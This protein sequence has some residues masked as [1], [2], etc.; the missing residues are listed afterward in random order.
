MKK[1]L[2]FIFVCIPMLVQAYDAEIDGIYYNFIDDEAE[3]TYVRQY[4][5]DYSGSITIPASVTFNGK[6]YPVTSIGDFAFHECDNLTSIVIPESVTNIGNAAFEG[7]RYLTNIN[8]PD[9]VITIG[10]QAFES[11]Y[12]LTS[13]VIPNGVTKIEDYTFKFCESMTSI[14]IPNSVTSIGDEAFSTCEFTNITI[15]N[16]VTSIGRAA[17]SHCRLLKTIT[18]PEGVTS[19]ES[20]TFSDCLALTDINI[21]ESVTSIGNIAFRLCSSL[22]K[23]TIPK[24][25]TKLGS[26]CFYGCSALTDVYCFAS[27]VPHTYAGVF[28][29]TSIQEGTLY[30]PEGS[31]ESYRS[32][33]PWSEFKNIFPIKDASQSINSTLADVTTDAACYDLSGRRYGVRHTG[34]FVKDGRKMIK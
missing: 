14:S 32:T 27:E 34:I 15:P 30:V 11:C 2:L 12:S 10:R 23:I 33:E 5:A 7:C 20:S 8:I 16:S 3:V 21:P 29:K 17:F 24:G 4:Q 25:V 13:V 9:G 1:L 18:I 28:S 26:Q 6:D 19:I 31:I 22:E